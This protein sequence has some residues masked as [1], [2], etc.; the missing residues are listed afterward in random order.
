MAPITKLLIKV[1]MFEWTNEC[2]IAW[3]DIKNQYIQAP[4]L[5]NIN[6]E[7][8]FHVHIDASQLAI[9]TILT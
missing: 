8:E 6:W 9:G 1:E 7:L 2:Q 5:I 4:I 3:E